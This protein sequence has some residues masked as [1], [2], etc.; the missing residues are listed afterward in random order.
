MPAWF[1][2]EQCE[3]KY[4]TASS[5]EASKFSDE[6]EK[7]GGNL[8]E[9]LWD[10]PELIERETIV[11]FHLTE[12][13]LTNIYQGKV[14]SLNGDEIGLHVYSNKSNNLLDEMATCY[15]SFS[16]SKRPKGR[17]YFNSQIL[18]FY[19]HDDHQVVIKT[20]EFLVRREER[21]SPRFELET[22]V[23]YRIADDFGKLMAM[24]DDNYNIGE[25]R[26][27]SKKG[28]LLVD[29]LGLS[30]V[31]DKYID[32][33]IEYDDY[34]I[35]TIGNIARVNSIDQSGDKKALGVKFLRRNVDTLKIIDEL[36]LKK[37]AN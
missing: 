13:Q 16:R 4:Y 25:T 17:F 3:E 32:L 37:V 1:R 10:V 31:N 2:C 35:S 30:V 27:I 28:L 34:K 7:C 15:L 20:P 24:A 11:D 33:K 18:G 19:D 21:S 8:Q 36:G 29:N 23:K 26:D 12:N 22:T 6:C 9:I 14:L 5:R